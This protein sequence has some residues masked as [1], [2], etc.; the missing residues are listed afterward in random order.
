MSW[1]KQHWRTIFRAIG[2]LLLLLGLF[3]SYLWFYTLAPSRRTLNPQ[4][5]SVHSQQDY[6]QELQKALHRSIWYHDDGFTVGWNGDKSWAEWI[7]NHVKPGTSMGCM[8]SKLCHSATSMEFISNQDVGENADAWLNW[9]GKNKSK[10]QLQWIAEGF[11]Q[12]GINVDVP[13][14]ADKM[15]VLLEVLGTSGTNRST[16]L[17]DSLKYN[18]FRC[19]RDSRFDPVEFALSTPTASAEIKRGLQEYAKCERRWPAAIGL[20][21]LPFAKKKDDWWSRTRTP[22]F[23]TPQFQP[24]AYA[25]IF[26]PLFLGIGLITWSIRSKKGMIESLRPRAG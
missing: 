10:S 4:W 2:I 5:C 16:T 17:L 23:V 22:P 11:V 3:V 15:P 21:I 20:G 18:A 26:G 6:W 19:L 13:P 7:M 8:G 9:W 12:R 24:I 1:L 14:R 25:L